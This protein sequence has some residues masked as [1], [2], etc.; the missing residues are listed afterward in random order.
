MY[1]HC[2]YFSLKKFK[3][4][5]SF[6]AVTVAFLYEY[7]SWLNQRNISKTTI[8]MYLCPYAPFSMKQLGM[9]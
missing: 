2:S 3:G 5:V 9:A 4:S 7:E 1:Y 6:E 8:G